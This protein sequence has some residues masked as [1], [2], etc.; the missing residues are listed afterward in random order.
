ML[1]PAQ[2]YAENRY[3]MCNFIHSSTV[4]SISCEQDWYTNQRNPKLH[5][6]S[7]TEN[8]HY[9][10]TKSAVFFCLLFPIQSY[11]LLLLF[12]LYNSLHSYFP[13]WSF[14][15]VIDCKKHS[16]W[17]HLVWKINES[18]NKAQERPRIVSNRND[19]FYRAGQQVF[20]STF[21]QANSS[22]W[23]VI[24]ENTF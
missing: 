12:L 7:Q 5:E 8:I 19:N 2:I 23:D 16:I 13:L 18:I 10:I 1:I 9:I 4:F 17:Q 20:S 24:T 6:L 21:W 15:S 3:K 11:V 14:S 22:E